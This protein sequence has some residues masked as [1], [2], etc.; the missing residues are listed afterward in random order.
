MPNLDVSDVLDDPDFVTSFTVKRT[1]VSVGSNGRSSAIETVTPTTGVITSDAGQNL[2]RTPD[3]R[4]AVGRI[5]IHTK[6][7]LYSGEDA[8]DADVI[9]WRGREWTIIVVNDYSEYG[10]GFVSAVAEIRSIT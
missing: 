8:T 1:V 10:L 3:A 4:N 9:V 2:S 5:M 7:F 6:F